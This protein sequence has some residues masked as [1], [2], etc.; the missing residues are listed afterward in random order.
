MSLEAKENSGQIPLPEER[1]NDPE[2]LRLTKIQQEQSSRRQAIR[3]RKL[4]EAADF[5]AE[6]FSIIAGNADLKSARIICWSDNNHIFHT[7]DE[8]H[9]TRIVELVAER[10]DVILTEGVGSLQA[11]GR[12]EYSWKKIWAGKKGIVVLGWDDA[13]AHAETNDSL[14]QAKQKYFKDQDLE[15]FAKRQK[16]I[17]MRT[18]PV[19]E[20]S[21]IKTITAIEND[22]RFAGKRIFIPSGAAHLKAK[23]VQ[24]ELQQF[25]FTVLQTKQ[26]ASLE[27]IFE[28][29]LMQ[30]EK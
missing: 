30:P 25:K 21:M 15:Y 26:D 24:Q 8:D 17:F 12:E 28:D 9:F 3:Q 10:G 18:S 11:S 20:R 13:K 16:E 29:F 22:K 7:E 2:F 27:S 4:D 5:A 6:H 19:R 1:S 23:A 14:H